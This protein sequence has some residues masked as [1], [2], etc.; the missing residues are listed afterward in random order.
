MRT[1]DGQARVATDTP[2]VDITGTVV[3]D[4]LVWG[5]P[6]DADAAGFK[7]LIMAT[8]ARYHGCSATATPEQI[9]VAGVAGI[10]QRALCA[11][12]FRTMTVALV[13][14]G[15]GLA[16]RLRYPPAKESVAP[17]DLVRWLDGLTWRNR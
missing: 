4:L 15:Y 7:D 17:R 16:F 5:L 13:R 10:G 6:W 12:D 2:N 3:G 8:M 9:V 14:N 1:W 11:Q